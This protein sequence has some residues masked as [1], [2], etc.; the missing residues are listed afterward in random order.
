MKFIKIYFFFISAF[1]I[2]QNVQVDS[3]T[4]TPQQLVEDILINSA[5]IENVI[6]TNIVGGD[7]NESDQSFGYFNANGSGFPFQSGIVLST[8]RLANVE[9]PNTSLSDDDANNWVGDS[10]LETI[11]GESNTHNA[12]IIEF[13]FV[14][15]ADQIS[16][17]YIFASEEY[18]E[19]D[20]STCQYSDLFGFL[21]RPVNSQQ[22]EN[23]ALVPNTQIPVKVT[24]VHPE[25]PGYCAAEN[26]A[27]FGSWNNATAPINFNG[28]T[29]VLTATANV[30]PNETYH[31]KL[32]IADEQNYR[33]DSAVFLEAGSFELSTDLGPD[34][35][36]ETNNPLCEN[37]Q[38]EVNALQTNAI[39]YKWFKDGVELLSELNPTYTI[40]DP[41][42]YQVE[43]TL[44]NSCISFGE[45]TIEYTTNPI[46][47]NATLN[48]CDSDSDGI[49]WFNLWQAEE[50]VTNNDTSLSVSNFFIS[51]SDAELNLNPINNPEIFLNAN[52]FQTVYA[53]VENQFYCYSISEILLT[54]SYNNLDLEPFTACDD[55]EIDGFTTF[56]LNDLENNLTA[57]LPSGA[58]I[59]FYETENDAFN[60]TNELSNSYTNN[61]QDEQT[62]FIKVK[63]NNQCYSLN[64]VVLKVLYTPQLE[65]DITIENPIYYCLNNYP[66]TI[67]LHAGVINDIPNNNNNYS[68]NTGENT[69]TIEINQP[70]TYQVIVTDPN[71]CSNSR[72]ITVV[73]SN[74]ATIEDV[75][76]EDGISN[77]SIA[78]IVSGEGDYQYSLNGVQYQDGNIF[79]NVQAGIYNIFIRD[80]NGCGIV[81]QEVAILGFP[82]FFTPNGDGY[83]DVWQLYG[84]S[85]HFYQGAKVY[86]NNR[87]GKLI[88]SFSNQNNGWDGTFNGEKLPSTDYW[89]V[90]N[91]PDGRVFHGHFSLKR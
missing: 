24:T 29:E 52:P 46:V 83:N 81:S 65:E 51:E 7:F 60:E 49:T 36:I 19:N 40:I 55:N 42:N 27:Y 48:E 63:V 25:I 35:L 75:I 79:T 9:G 23:I 90:V 74:I 67:T 32:V 69:S 64:T 58:V 6:V 61:V 50:D 26:E 71:G 37:E 70:D 68:W 3:Q 39:S 33:Y 54:T 45:I 91:L 12:T 72:S 14:A 47:F 85:A 76:I 78:I 28:Q 77:N 31:V 84:V 53:R 38:L 62:I 89:F 30:I 73:A 86:I 21:I 2:G 80:N 15:V 5:C 43:V 11:L 17:R 66:E 8:G 82:K 87:Y 56:N 13:E 57:S 4:Y 41:G 20:S 44:E 34:R 88:T 10:D 1:C 16:F 59:S 18:Q 22:Y